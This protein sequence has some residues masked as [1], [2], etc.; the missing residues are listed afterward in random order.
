MGAKYW[1]YQFSIKVIWYEYTLNI[2]PDV[3]GLPVSYVFLLCSRNK[4]NWSE[5]YLTLHQLD[6]AG[7]LACDNVIIKIEFSIVAT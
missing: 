7:P 4:K 6:Q 1:A 2:K 3:L 5:F